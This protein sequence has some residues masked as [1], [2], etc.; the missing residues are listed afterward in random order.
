MVLAFLDDGLDDW[1]RGGGAVEELGR[2]T[3]WIMWPSG[4]GG[5]TVG[6]CE[7]S[8]WSWV[9]ETVVTARSR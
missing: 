5:D 3:V 1:M 6:E 7:G 2:V 8:A 4:H 9:T